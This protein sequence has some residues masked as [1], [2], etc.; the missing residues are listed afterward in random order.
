[1]KKSTLLETANFISSSSSALS[2]SQSGG[3][4]HLYVDSVKSSSNQ[5]IVTSELTD[6]T[7]KPIESHN[8][9]SNSKIE[10]SMI[11]LSNFMNN[12]YFLII[13]LQFI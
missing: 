1:M 7:I 5:S 9:R 6:F 10:L 12:I 11:N 2:S 8:L 3:S 13:K 4:F